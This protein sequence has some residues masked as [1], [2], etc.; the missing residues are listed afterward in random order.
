MDYN[1]VWK[2][3]LLPS[4]IPL[5]FGSE[6]VIYTNETDL[7]ALLVE[8]GIYK[9]KSQARKAGRTGLIPSG[10]NEIKAGKRDFLFLW[11]PSE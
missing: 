5:L 7:P 8:L 3:N 10:Y 1:V 2:E 6:S 11:K 4:D 9:S